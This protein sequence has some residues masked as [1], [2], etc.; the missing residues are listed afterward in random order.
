M[1]VFF[2]LAALTGIAVVAKVQANHFLATKL[3]YNWNYQNWLHFAMLLNNLAS[4]QSATTVSIHAILEFTTPGP[5]SEFL[6]PHAVLGE[7]S[8][9]MKK[10]GDT[11]MEEKGPGQACVIKL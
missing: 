10:L 1:G 4:M 11:L 9:W 3:W 8:P 6:T 7:Y 2:F 5:F